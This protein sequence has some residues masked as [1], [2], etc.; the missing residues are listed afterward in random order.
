MTKETITY[1]KDEM[2]DRSRVGSKVKYD[3]TRR[4]GHIPVEDP[5]VE[6]KARMS[7]ERDCLCSSMKDELT[8]ERG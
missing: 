6:V 3:R 2:V 8:D 1:K 4:R 7:T 5:T